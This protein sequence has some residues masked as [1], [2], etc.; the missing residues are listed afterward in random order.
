MAKTTARMSAEERRESVIRAAVTEFAR[1]GYV[2]TSTEAIAR[3]VG[4]S[5]PYLFRLFPNKRAIFLAAAL[6]CLADTRQAFD[7]A[8]KG[9]DDP[10]KRQ[11]AMAMAYFG[12]IADRDHLMMQMQMYVAVFT[13]EE[14]GDL[15]FGEQIRAAWAEMWDDLHLRLGPDVKDTTEFM[16]YGMLINTLVSMGFPADHRVWQGFDI[17]E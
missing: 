11:D 16:G 17:R 2:G 5:Q 1:G 4:V 15:E 12:L 9:I 6:R 14:A 10:E 8:V 3:R 7:K 13:A